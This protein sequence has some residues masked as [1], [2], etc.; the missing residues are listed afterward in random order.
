MRYMIYLLAVLNLFFLLWNVAQTPPESGDVRVLPPSPAGASPIETLEESQATKF[1]DDDVSGL[2]RLTATKPPGAGQGLACRVLGPVAA[3]WQ[4]EAIARRLG[5]SGF[6]ARRRSSEIKVQTGYWVYLP[7]ME[8]DDATRIVN[9]LD[10]ANDSEYFVGKDNMI[11]LGAF[12]DLSRAEVRLESVR[13]LGL[14]P[15]LEPTYE[16]RSVHW[17]DLEIATSR[18][19]ELDTVMK[20]YP[21]IRVRNEGCQ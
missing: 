20:E 14:D 18:E 7:T 2:G 15:L 1:A 19:A 4:A 8:H 9:L 13:K 17:L 21:D 5:V 6:V 11:S 10:E 3:N 16:N 12:E